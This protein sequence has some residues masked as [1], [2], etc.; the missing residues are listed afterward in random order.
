MVR[1]VLDVEDEVI[2]ILYSTRDEATQ[3]MRSCTRFLSVEVP[4]KADAN[5]LLN[6]L[7]RGLLCLGITE[8]LEM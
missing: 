8:I 3:E 2:V 7:S 4:M 1:L 5:G 6:C